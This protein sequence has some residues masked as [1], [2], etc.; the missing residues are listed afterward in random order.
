MSP[1]RVEFRRFVQHIPESNTLASHSLQL[2][3][4]AYT[5]KDV[6]A[7]NSSLCIPL[8]AY[9]FPATACCY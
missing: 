7:R 5:T 6:T 4:H 1:G 2:E 9:P 8:E 3:P